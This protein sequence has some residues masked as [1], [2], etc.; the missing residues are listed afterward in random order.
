MCKHGLANGCFHCHAHNIVDINASIR[1][2]RHRV[3]REHRAQN[4]AVK[5]HLAMKRE[6]PL[7]VNKFRNKYTPI[8]RSM[9]RWTMNQYAGN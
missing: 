6:G 8:T 3:T 7:A 1:E 9:A 2:A 4:Y 5:L